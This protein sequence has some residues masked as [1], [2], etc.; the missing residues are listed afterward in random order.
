MS[1][2]LLSSTKLNDA[3]ELALALAAQPSL[4]AARDATSLLWLRRRRRAKQT[5]ATTIVV[6]SNTASAMKTHT[7]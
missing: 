6:S 2:A 7:I 5:N 3:A 4:A 1:V